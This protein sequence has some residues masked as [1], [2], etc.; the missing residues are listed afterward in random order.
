MSR[1]SAKRYEGGNVSDYYVYRLEDALKT[2]AGG[3]LP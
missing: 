2:F 1:R 3:R